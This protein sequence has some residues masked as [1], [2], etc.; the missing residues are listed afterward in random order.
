MI[1]NGHKT[2]FSTD[3][4]PFLSSMEKLAALKPAFKK[5]GTVTAGNSSG[6][7]DGASA[8]LVMSEDKVKEFGYKPMAK[9]ISVGSSGCDPTIMGLGPVESSIL[10][11]KRAGLTLHD[12]DIIEL[13]EAF[14]A[15]SI[16]VIKEW[17]KLGISEEA[18]LSKINPNGGAIAH[19]HALGNTGA[20]LTVKCMYEMQRR[21][22]ARYGMITMCCAGGVGVAAIIE[23]C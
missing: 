11:M 20:A 18:L 1:D 23:K 22:T 17:E 4:H 12:L 15:Q 21:E 19:G 5:E 3:E 2:L 14:A 13:N 8:V 7:N 6:R 9:I 16:A 10:A